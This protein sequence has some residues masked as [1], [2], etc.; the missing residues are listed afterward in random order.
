MKQTISAFL[1]FLMLATLA[2][3]SPG[4]Q[5]ASGVAESSPAPA[6]QPVS[7]AEDEDSKPARLNLLT[8]L[9][10]TEGSGAG[11]VRPA[12]VVV[13]NIWRARPNSGLPQAD[14]VFETEVWEGITRFLALYSDSAAMPAV[15]PVREMYA[16]LMQCGLPAQ[17]LFVSDNVSG[18]SVLLLEQLAYTPY[19]FDAQFG[20]NAT[21]VDERRAAAGMPVEYTRYTDGGTLT[22]AVQANG[23]DTVLDIAPFFDFEESE[24][25]GPAVG[26]AVAERVHIIFS[27]MFM[28]RFC[29]DAATARYRMEQSDGDD[30]FAPSV[31]G[32]DGEQI[33][34]D[35]VLVLFAQVDKGEEMAGDIQRDVL[36]IRFDK[37]GSG[38]YCR[39]GEAVPLEWQNGGEAGRFA[40]NTGGSGLALRPGTTYVAVVNVEREPDFEMGRE[41]G[42]EE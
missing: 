41:A 2:A 13:D 39:G 4:G 27:D 1:C 35:N 12:A 26:D 37:G 22:G 18:P 36:Q 33:A 23:T 10:V 14:I 34:F 40:L 5:A 28:T 7:A 30:A 6:A 20:R 3:C 31:D 21:W 25:Q 29:Y 32:A 15:G 11:S 17:P 16:A 42:E 38:Y 24:A 19:V 8:G 9:P